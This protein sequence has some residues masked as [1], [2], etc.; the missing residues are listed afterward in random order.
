MQASDPQGHP[1]KL[2]ELYS[3]PSQK[4]NFVTRNLKFHR[5]ARFSLFKKT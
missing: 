3:T 1:L 4:P 2:C 5:K